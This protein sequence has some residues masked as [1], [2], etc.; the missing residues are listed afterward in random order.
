[1]SSV[2][3]VASEPKRARLEAGLRIEPPGVEPAGALPLPIA[4]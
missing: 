4:R 1:M 3:W 2:P